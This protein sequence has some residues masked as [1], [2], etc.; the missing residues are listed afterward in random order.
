MHGATTGP[1]PNFPPTR[2]GMVVGPEE[3][4][5]ARGGRG[6]QS[7]GRGRGGRATRHNSSN[8]DFLYNQF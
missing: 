8:D 1:M 3:G 7:R 6:G 5:G 2:R 4:G